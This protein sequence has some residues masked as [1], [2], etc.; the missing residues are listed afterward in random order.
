MERKFVTDG[1]NGN[2]TLIYVKL[3]QEAAPE[4]LPEILRVMCVL[5][6]IVF[7]IIFL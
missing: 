4:S 3:I 2:Y 1:L 7:L 6:E 5:S